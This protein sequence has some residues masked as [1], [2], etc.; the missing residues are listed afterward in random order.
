MRALAVISL[1][2]GSSV[3]IDWNGNWAL[4]C[5][6]PGNDLSSAQTRGEDCGGRCASTS[7]CTHFTWTDYNGGTCWMKTNSVSKANAVNKYDSSAVCGVI[8]DGPGPQPGPSGAGK[9]TRYWD[10]CKVI[11]LSDQLL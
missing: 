2:M 11:I 10:C 9:S 4:N 3:S 5:D 8:N 1:L 7:G 6:F